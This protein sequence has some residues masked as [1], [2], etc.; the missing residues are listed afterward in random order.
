MDSKVR[1]IALR[2]LTLQRVY[3]VLIGM[4]VA[5][6]HGWAQ[7]PVSADS[8]SKWEIG[9]WVSGATGKENVHSY[10]E[11]QMLRAGVFVGRAV[12]GELGDKWWR[13]SLEYGINLVPLTRTLNAQHVYGGGFEPVVLRWNSFVRR[14]RVAPYLELAGGGLFTTANLPAGDTS[15]VN[16]TARGGVG[17]HVFVRDRKSVDLGCDWL[18]IS[19]ANLGNRNPQFNGV[20][21]SLG[22]HWYW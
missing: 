20:Q 21:V 10:T 12:T 14:G 7:V 8:E 2:E 11:E 9:V 22:Y 19:N 3:F 16:F 17:V 18:H 6:G 13:G 1:S 5:V 15:S 4:L